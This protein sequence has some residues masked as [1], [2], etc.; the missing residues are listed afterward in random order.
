MQ[1]KVSTIWLGSVLRVTP[2]TCY[3]NAEFKSFV[4]T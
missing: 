4:H 3:H 1:Y 2:D